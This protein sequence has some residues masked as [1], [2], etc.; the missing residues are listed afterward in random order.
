MEIGLTLV[1]SFTWKHVGYPL[2]WGRG[3]PSAPYL[4]IEGRFWGL[5]AVA[6]AILRDPTRMGGGW[7]LGPHPL[8][9]SREGPGL[10]GEV[11][12]GPRCDGEPGELSHWKSLCLLHSLCSP[13]RH[14]WHCSVASDLRLSQ[15]G[16]SCPLWVVGMRPASPETAVLHRGSGSD[17]ELFNWKNPIGW[18]VHSFISQIFWAP[19]VASSALGTE[20]WWW[21]AWKQPPPPDAHSPG[22]WGRVTQKDNVV[23][24][25]VNEKPRRKNSTTQHS[26][27]AW[28]PMGMGW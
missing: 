10:L 18:L 4:D 23:G 7:A 17:L 3:S 22:A 9:Q 8:G 20:V 27:Q 24:G 28:G 26:T 12:K 16:G 21:V 1:G 25:F 13:L 5:S 2:L 6:Q 19:R 11:R 15:T 14:V